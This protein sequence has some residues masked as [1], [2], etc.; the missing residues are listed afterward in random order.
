MVFFKRKIVGESTLPPLFSLSLQKAACLKFA[1]I[2]E[3][4]RKLHKKPSIE[5]APA[6]AA[7]E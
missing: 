2:I 5:P 7:G 3:F 6:G 4:S 1:G